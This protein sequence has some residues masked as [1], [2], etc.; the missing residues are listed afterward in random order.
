MPPSAVRA[1]LLLALAPAT[2]VALESQTVEPQPEE[3]PVTLDRVQVIA[4]RTPQASA[5]VP[6]SVSVIEGADLSTDTLGATLSEKLSSVPGL[7]ARNRQNLAQ[8]EQLSI[9]GFGT[10]ASFGIRG[11]RLLVD[12][13]PATMPDGQGQV[14]H[15]NLAT[16]QRIEVLRG[17]FS[18]L[19][20]N[21]SGGVIQLFTADGEAPPSVGLALAG[22]SYGAHRA[23]V[24][25]RGAND[26]LDYTLGLTRFGT[27]GYRD[28]SRATRTSLNGKG[29]IT[30]GASGTLTVLL[31][32]LHA[33]DAQDPQ[34]L[35]R[36]QFEQDPHQASGGALQF[37]TRKSVSQQQ[38]GLVYERD[39][40]AHQLRLLGYGGDRHISQFLS[41]P[42]ATQR[43]P[44]SPGGV[45]DLRAP[46]AG[47]DVRW[48]HAGTLAQRPLEFAVGMNFDEQQQDRQGY[49][50]FIATSSGELRL[51]VRGA[52]RLQQDDQVQAFDQYAQA[53]WRPAE[54]WSL[55]A[56]LRH[57]EVR[58]VSR[59]RYITATNPDDSG[60]ARYQATSPVFGIN[61]R[62]RPSLHLYAAHGRGF[63]TP[64]FNELGYRADGGSGLNFDLRAARTRSSEAGLK[65][66]GARLRSEFA[67]FRAD[68][69]DELTVNTS[70]GGRTTFRNAGHARRTGAEWSLDW[71]PAEGWRVQVALTHIDARFREGFLACAAI[72][73][74]TPNVPVAPDT[75]I[76]GVPR[77]TGYAALHWGDAD[78][79]HARLDGQY[80]A[81]VP[82]DNLGEEQADAYVVF[83]ASAGHG[84]RFGESDGRV[85]VG[86]GNLFDRS[87]VGSVI[88]NEA[89]RRHFEPAPDRN[90]VAGIELRWR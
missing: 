10:R 44:L 74:T 65:F 81:A 43:N 59:D 80:V 21:A 41:V 79:W 87:H 16:T 31:N 50:N 30:V 84:L 15:F 42:V 52:L 60:R 82:V 83:G 32:A 48:T 51:G 67:V 20:G 58:F 38:L 45:I 36:E 22:G 7:L 73:C 5:E 71:R 75:R 85:Y 39:I 90:F 27:D 46:Y 86:V 76:P 68:T 19:Y 49:E 70:S 2:A 63:E 6:A 56:G 28:H 69:D 53:T 35:T 14:S 8:D 88:V 9:R 34:G 25:A 1:L 23:S 33:P 40:G 11:L 62:V 17:P 61:W 66:D 12:G 4:T 47:I 37:D 72:P 18:A 78:G 64:T 89:N 54:A 24:D 26:R 3:K 29:N 55:M 57:S 77:N 13:V